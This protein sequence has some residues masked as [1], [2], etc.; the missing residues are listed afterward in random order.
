MLTADVAFTVEV[1][2]V[3]QQCT[4][5]CLAAAS[6][7]GLGHLDECDHSTV[8]VD[9]MI[10]DSGQ[11]ELPSGPCRRHQHACQK[12]TEKRRVIRNGHEE[13]KGWTVAAARNGRGI[14]QQVD[15]V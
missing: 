1:D 9:V 14:V 7:F 13:L 11:S 12:Y 5:V 3:R 6:H 15:C 10:F 4:R 2:G 8:N